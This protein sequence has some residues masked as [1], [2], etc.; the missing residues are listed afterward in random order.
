MILDRTLRNQ[1]L[2]QVGP[3]KVWSFQ[4]LPV[5]LNLLFNCRRGNT[6]EQLADRCR[7]PADTLRRSVETYNLAARGETTDPLGKSAP[8][9][10]D[11]GQGPGIAWICPTTAAFTL[12][13][14]DLGRTAGVRAKR[15]GARPARRP[16]RRAVRRRPLRRGRCV[17]PVCLGPVPGRLCLFWRA[18]AHVAELAASQRAS[19]GE[20]PCNAQLTRGR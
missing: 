20:H 2:A 4:R 18:A 9:L 15:P 7:L 10:H 16:H 3:G 1:A 12:P 11:L 6:L 17:E 14:P 13:D 8:M 19:E 5:L